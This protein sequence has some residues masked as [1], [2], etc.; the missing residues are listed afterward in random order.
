MVDTTFLL[1]VAVGSAC[2]GFLTGFAVRAFT[3]RQEQ[4][5]EGDETT[6][7]QDN[8]S[9][10]KKAP[11]K[12]WVEMA[13]LWRDGRDGKL[14]FQVGDE[15]YKQG[16]DLT[17]KER[18]IL[19]KIVMDFY[20]WLEP[21]AAAPVQVE[22]PVLAA[23]TRVDSVPVSL[24]EPAKKNGNGIKPVSMNPVNIL[25]RALDADVATSSLPPQSMV[26]QVDAILQEKLQAE[27]MQQWAVR[28]AEF[29]NK[30]MMVLVGLEQYEGI[31]E[32]PYERVRKLIRAS[33]AEWERRVEVGELVAL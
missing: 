6:Q 30:G 12:N 4:A 22:A 14:I 33:V 19:L 27:K 2:L 10:P 15:S 18:K 7:P 13:Q 11:R 1:F 28:L 5:G 21:P 32:V 8:P 31:D 3:R 25:A 24:Q 29:P 9:T 16:S 23:A 17:T 20:R 26:A